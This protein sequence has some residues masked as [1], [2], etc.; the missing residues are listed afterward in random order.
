MAHK[1]LPRHLWAS[2]DTLLLALDNGAGFPQPKDGMPNH[3]DP[4]SN[5]LRP[6]EATAD[7]EVE[8]HPLPHE[9]LET[10]GD[11]ESSVCC[12]PKSN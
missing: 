1:F 5:T 6:A 9:V 3:P 2:Y 7:A 10:V 4:A 8:L 12:S 11:T